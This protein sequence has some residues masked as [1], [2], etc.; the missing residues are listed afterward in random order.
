MKEWTRMS[1]NESEADHFVYKGMQN[2]STGTDELQTR[3]AVSVQCNV[4]LFMRQAAASK[5]IVCFEIHHCAWRCEPGAASVVRL[6]ASSEVNCVRRG[7][8]ALDVHATTH[9]SVSILICN[10]DAI[11]ATSRTATADCHW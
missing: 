5:T 7:E 4:F 8:I 9:F 10:A 2:L 3:R 1:K 11:R 6:L